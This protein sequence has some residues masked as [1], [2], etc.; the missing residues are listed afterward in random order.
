MVKRQGIV[1]IMIYGFQD[2]DSTF[3]E[4]LEEFDNIKETVDCGDFYFVAKS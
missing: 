1:F 2:R 3:T 4:I